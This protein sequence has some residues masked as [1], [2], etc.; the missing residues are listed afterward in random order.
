MPRQ[1]KKILVVDDES[2]IRDGV[3]RW[4][5]AA[6]FD[7]LA[8][9][10]GNQGLRTASQSTPD[11]ILLDVLMP[12]KDGMETLA[13]LKAN[14]ETVGIPVVMLSASLRDQQRALDAGARFFVQKPYNGKVLVHTV[15]A[16]INQRV[17]NYH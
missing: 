1:P 15:N 13:E 11:A 10:D 2:E 8:A 5:K 3:T 4:L 16:A 14:E 7:T 12:H 9:E 17:C 6:G